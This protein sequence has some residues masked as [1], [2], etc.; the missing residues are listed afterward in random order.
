GRTYGGYSRCAGKGLLSVLV[1]VVL[2]AVNAFCIGMKCIITQFI[3]HILQ[4][5]QAGSHPDGYSQNVDKSKGFVF[6]QITKGGFQIVCEH[7]TLRLIWWKMVTTRKT[8]IKA[9][10]V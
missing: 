6:Q 8:C 5:Q 10:H 1:V 9:F 4:N 3:H 7:G 2:D